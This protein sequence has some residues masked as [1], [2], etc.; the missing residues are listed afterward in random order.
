MIGY[1]CPF[2]CVV[3]MLFQSNGLVLLLAIK[4]FFYFWH[5]D[6]GKSLSRCISLHS[7]KL[8]R[9]GLLTTSRVAWTKINT[10]QT[11]LLVIVTRTVA[12]AHNS[13][14][15]K[16][17]NCKS[18]NKKITIRFWEVLHSLL[19]NVQSCA[20][21]AKCQDENGVIM[22]IRD[23]KFLLGCQPLNSL[24]WLKCYFQETTSPSVVSR[25]DS[26][27]ACH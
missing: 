25:G 18:N 21:L 6:I 16:E 8:V 14:E 1:A 22:V 2:I 27:V 26:S 13:F 17:V 5:E 15:Q 9:I 20:Y 11:S 24:K 4:P 19:Q 10:S 3:S 12:L 23:P 7:S